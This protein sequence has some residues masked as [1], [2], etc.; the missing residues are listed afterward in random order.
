M[1]GGFGEETFGVG[2][3]GGGPLTLVR[4][5]ALASHVVRVVFNEEPIHRSGAGRFDALNPANYLIIA[6]AGEISG[7]VFSRAPVVSAVGVDR[8]MVRGPALGADAGDC[9]FDVH[10]DRA[11]VTAVTYRVG[12]IRIRSHAGGELGTPYTATFLGVARPAAVD[13]PRRPVAL[14]DWANLDGRWLVDSSGDLSLDETAASLRKRVL[15]RLTT[16]R[17]AFTFLPE[18]GVGLRLKSPANRA[19]LKTLVPEIESQLRREPEVTAVAVAVEQSP[20]GLL[21]VSL[22]IRTRGGELGLRVTP[23]NAGVLA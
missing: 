15:R 6:A 16:I 11:M 8:Q 1:M 20:L 22:Q 12:V 3:G 4:A 5:R 23:G 18:Y 7:T 19:D 9:A 2:L 14:I 21:T 10:T 13:P 17:G